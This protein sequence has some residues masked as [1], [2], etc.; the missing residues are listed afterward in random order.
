[1]NIVPLKKIKDDAFIELKKLQVGEKTLPKTGEDFI[2]S[3]LGCILPGDV[4]LISALSGQGKTETL[5]R[6]KKKI[7][8]VE[9]NKDAMNYVFLDVSLEMKL[10]NI[11]LRGLSNVIDKKKSKILFEEFTEEEKEKAKKYYETLDDDRQYISQTP[12]TPLE[13]YNGTKTFL[14]EHSDKE[15][16]FIALD[17]V[18]LMSGSNKQ[19]VLE[20]L[21]EHINQLKLSFSN[22]YFILISQNNRGLLGRI[23]EKNN[24]AAPNAGD[25]FGSSFLDQLCSFNIILYNPFKMGIEQ[26]MKV[27]PN[28]YEYLSEHFGEE[29]SKG[30]VSFNTQ[31]K[32][33]VHMIKTRESDNNYSNLFVIEMDSQPEIKEPEGKLSKNPVFDKPDPIFDSE[34]Y[35]VSPEDAFGEPN[36]KVDDRPF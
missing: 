5:Q 32:I 29:D 26:Y 27:N 6:M 2:D 15:A 19:E 1:M 30:R 20:Q 11:I 14:E 17:H 31:G 9:V 4:I 35:K 24:N 10:F 3:H 28:R 23:A 33:F 13:F 22:A 16:V 7:L 34:K 25:V 21:C 18:L 8:S 36:K 12:T